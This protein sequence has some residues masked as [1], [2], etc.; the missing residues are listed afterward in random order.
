MSTRSEGHHTGSAVTGWAATVRPLAFAVGAAAAAA[1]EARRVPD[2]LLALPPA[3]RQLVRSAA[4]RSRTRYEELAA[5]GERIVLGAGGEPDAGLPI[6]QASA[7]AMPDLELV[8]PV[9]PSAPAEP[10]GPSRP[11]RSG[12]VRVAAAAKAP[13]AVLGHDELPLEDFDHLT[14]PQLRG[15]IRALDEVE[16]AR[17]RDY[18]R[19]HGDRLPVL[20]LLDNRITALQA[21]PH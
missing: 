15:R 5:R 13:G 2:R 9:E 8:E 17:L 10:A 4:E 6:D 11:P 12:A 7:G 21:Q 18:E 20:T 14:L 16:L 19:A 1:E 3:A